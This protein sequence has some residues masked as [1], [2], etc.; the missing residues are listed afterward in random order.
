[1]SK[2]LGQ[3]RDRHQ[4]QQIIVGLSEG[5]ILV[6]PEQRIVWANDAALAMHGCEQVEDLG[7]TVDET[8]EVF[9]CAIAISTRSGM[10]S[11]H[12]ARDCGRD[13]Q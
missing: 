13:L 4:L 7:A 5:V 10:A 6:D 3:S 1:M 8:V 9:N 11:T 2:A 12:R